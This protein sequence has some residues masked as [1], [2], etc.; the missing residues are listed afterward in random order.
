M[1]T[2]QAVKELADW[3]EAI[4]QRN[5][6]SA[7]DH[8]QQFRHLGASLI[9]SKEFQKH[10]KEQHECRIEP[11]E[12]ECFCRFLATIAEVEAGELERQDQR[13]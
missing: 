12:L 9:A 6:E 13:E 2:N 8:L 5:G 3:A 4:K 1:I 7:G 11:E 10:F